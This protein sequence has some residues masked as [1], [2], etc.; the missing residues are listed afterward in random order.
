MMP[1]SVLKTVNLLKRESLD[2]SALKK[3][4]FSSVASGTSNSASG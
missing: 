2:K 4:D 3:V 1:L